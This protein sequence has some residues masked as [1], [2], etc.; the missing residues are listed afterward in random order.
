MRLY[1]L[2]ISNRR[3][4]IYCQRLNRQLTPATS[5]LDR[6]TDRAARKWSEWEKETSGW[7]KQ[8]TQ[9]GNQA[10]QRISYEEW[11]LKSIP[12][13]SQRRQADELE[14]QKSVE[15]VYPGNVIERERVPEVLRRL[16]TDKQSLHRKRMWWSLV[17]IPFTAPVALLPIIPNI[18]FFYLTFRCWS[19]WRAL[20]GSKHVEFL[21]E[22][23]LLQYQNSSVIDKIYAHNSA[24]LLSSFSLRSHSDPLPQATDGEEMLLTN[25]SHKAFAEALDY[26]EIGMEVDR[27]VRQVQK[28]IQAKA[29]APDEK[30]EQIRTDVEE[31][32]LDKQKR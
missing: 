32:E 17:G 20:N 18:P 27:G 4:L 19:H 6:L 12:P 8:V 1:L 7:K 16:A 13:L 22:N 15:V 9:Y 11:G 30:S 28:L 3:A 10:L 29:E 24:G 23:K 14:G 5:P 26:P 21:L 25:S 31:K 2:P